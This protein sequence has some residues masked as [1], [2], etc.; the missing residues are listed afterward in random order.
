MCVLRY[1][2]RRRRRQQAYKDF[3]HTTPDSGVGERI[4]LQPVSVSSSTHRD[5][6][7]TQPER[8]SDQNLVSEQA[9]E[10]EEGTSRAASAADEL[11]RC[12]RSFV[13]RSRTQAGPTS[14]AAPAKITGC[15]GGPTTHSVTSTPPCNDTISHFLTNETV[16]NSVSVR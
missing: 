6:A 15:R 13:G 10:V 16:D 11:Q 1:S 14:S 7:R 12:C 8:T 9:H 3:V 2:G 4:S 5:R